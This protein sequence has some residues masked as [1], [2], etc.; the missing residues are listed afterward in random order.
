VLAHEA[1]EVVLPNS[2]FFQQAHFWPF[3]KT[4]ELPITLCGLMPNLQSST[5]KIP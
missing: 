2:M 5:S 4:I 1:S 3:E